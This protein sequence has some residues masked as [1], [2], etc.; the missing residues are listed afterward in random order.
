MVETKVKLGFAILLLAILLAVGT[1]MFHSLERYPSYY[2]VE[3]LQGR[4]WTY[5]DSFYF[6]AMTLTTIGYGDL[7]P[8]TDF[9]KIVTVFYAMMGVALALY[10]LG[11]IARWYVGRSQQFEEHEIE[12]LKHLLHRA[13]MLGRVDDKEPKSLPKEP[14]SGTT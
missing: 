13:Y 1:V 2:R 3:G 5:V 10:V 11:L 12:R 4:Q 7:Y 14:P 8:S 9:T 6:S